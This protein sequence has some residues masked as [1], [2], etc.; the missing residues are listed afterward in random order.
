VSI[1][2]LGVAILN[3]PDLLDQMLASIDVPVEQ[4]VVVDNGGVADNIGSPGLLR[5]IRINPGHNLG[6]AASWNLVFK[7]TPLAPWWCIVGSDVRFPEQGG[8]LQRLA[9]EMN[10]ATGPLFVAVG[11]YSCFAINAAALQLVGLFDENFIPAYYEDNDYSR[12]IELAGVPRINH[13][14]ALFHELSSTINSDEHLK[15]EN[16]RT[17][18]ENQTYYQVKWG[19]N[20]LYEKF[21]T[22][23]DKGGDIRDWALD[24]DRLRRLTWR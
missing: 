16:S 18:F 9:D 13:A 1:P 6:V 10:A 2:V 8:T 12:R 3:R 14:P 7:S 5:D 4:I 23:F 20:P 24:F 15:M 21:A 17:F 19:G 11:T 22:P